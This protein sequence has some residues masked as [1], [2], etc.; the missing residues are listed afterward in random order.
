VNISSTTRNG[1]RKHGLIKFHI[2]A[3]QTSRGQMKNIS[4]AARWWQTRDESVLLFWFW[5]ATS[6]YILNGFGILLSKSNLYGL[7]IAKTV[8][9]RGKADFL[10]TQLQPKRKN[11]GFSFG[12][13]SAENSSFVSGFQT[14]PSLQQTA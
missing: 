3:P 10:V 1:K 8:Q 4:A 5:F 13:F 12:S 2:L 9:K 14:D 11:L 6:A 7:L